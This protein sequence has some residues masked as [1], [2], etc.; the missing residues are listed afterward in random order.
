MHT[1]ICDSACS[2]V[3]RVARPVRKPTDLVRLHKFSYGGLATPPTPRRAE[4]Y[5]ISIS[6]KVNSVVFFNNIALLIS[7]IKRF[8]QIFL[9]T[10]KH[11]EQ[12]NITIDVMF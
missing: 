11:I 10:S 2:S 1:D 5:N 3:G 8:V 6:L 12:N 7:L 4:S 9:N